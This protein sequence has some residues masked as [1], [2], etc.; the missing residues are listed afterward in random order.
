MMNTMNSPYLPLLALLV[1][2][3]IVGAKLRSLGTPKY[4]ARVLL[5]ANELEFFQRLRRALP[6]EYIFP[7]VA[8]SALIGPTSHGKRNLQDF[9]KIS[10]KR[11]DFAIYTSSLELLALIELDDRTHDRAKD[12]KR[13]A[14]VASAGIRTLRFESRNKPNHAEIRAA[15]F[16]S[17]APTADG[18][19]SRS[20][21]P[22]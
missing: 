17:T 12:A 8:L 20:V 18:I 21:V 13:D 3:L 4:R 16:P 22:N 14:F 1:V 9:R 15:V 6:D 19:L 10:Q 11:V 2:V 7:Q 5:T